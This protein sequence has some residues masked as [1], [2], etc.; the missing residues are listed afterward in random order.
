MKV[1]V[2]EDEHR[3]ANYIKKGLSQKSMVVDVAYNGEEGYDLASSEEY[4]VIVLDRMLPKMD[5]V[6]VT[7]KLRENKIYTPI[8]MLTAKGE[9]SDR[10]EGLDAGADDYLPKPFAFTELIARVKSLARRPKEVIS[11]EIKITDLRMNLN[12]YEVERSGKKIKLSRKEFSLLEFL[13][14][15]KGQV[16]SPQELT[17]KVWS[18]DSDVLPNTAQVYM[19]YLRKKLDK[20][21]PEEKSLIKTVRGFGYTLNDE[22]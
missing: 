16:F 5:G 6:E 11:N 12:T 10:V 21:F 3:I 20:N 2:T 22:G 14:Q 18:Y 8:L 13:V 15:N 7:K 19:G 1:L 9:V 4:D 17:E